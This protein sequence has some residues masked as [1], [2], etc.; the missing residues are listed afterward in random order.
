VTVFSPRQVRAKAS[1]TI[2]RDIS[3]TREAV[4]ELKGELSSQLSFLEHDFVEQMRTNVQMLVDRQAAA[5]ERLAALTDKL[6]HVESSVLSR[7][8]E[9]ETKN[10]ESVNAAANLLAEWNRAVAD[11]VTAVDS[12]ISSQIGSANNSLFELTNKLAH[13]ESSLLSR[14]NEVQSASVE[15]VSAW[16]PLPLLS[17]LSD[18]VGNVRL[19]AQNFSNNLDNAKLA[20]VS[21][22]STIENDILSRLNQLETL[23]FESTNRLLTA[24]GTTASQLSEIQQRG[25]E[26]D[27]VVHHLDT[28]LHTRFNEVLFVQ[29]P[30]V[31]EQIHE[32]C[33]VQIDALDRSSKKS[34]SNGAHMERPK[35][36]S[37]EP[38]EKILARAERDFP[39]VFRLWKERLDDT[40]A[41]FA[42]TKVGNAANGADIY[43]RLFRVFVGGHIQG[44]VLDIGCGPFGR[45]YYLENYPAELISGIE[46]LPFP[47]NKEI[48][49]LRGISEYLPF[50]DNSFDTL[51]SGTSL[52]HCVDLDRS[53]DEMIRVLKPD[54]LALFW[55]GS[56]PG[57]PPFRPLAPDFTPAD[58]YHLFHFDIVWFEPV[59]EERFEILKR[60]KL[61]RAGYSHVFYALRPAE[62]PRKAAGPRAGLG[63][64]TASK[65]GHRNSGGSKRQETAGE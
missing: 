5:D 41:A 56:N 32:A 44:Q 43:S 53:L 20:M 14:L 22:L 55:L 37:V 64:K 17:Q 21:R 57:S 23:G 24:L 11:R 38:F 62:G 46:P 51:I 27:N 61:D 54:G 42:E 52:D 59:L 19:E 31:L 33:A 40:G 4:R 47:A 30:S 50:A 16:S 49:I 2:A 10:L 35:P 18:T 15:A 39:S 3:E 28:S 13:A 63:A 8:N 48:Q 36:T 65:T 25:A 60:V 12:V 58:R 6:V 29:L 26:L 9:I 34:L 7:L 45:P 1:D